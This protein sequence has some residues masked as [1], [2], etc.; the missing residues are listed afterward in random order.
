MVTCV[1]QDVYDA[2]LDAAGGVV[3]CWWEC[4]VK[5]HKCV[6]GQILTV[7]ET[8]SG[9]VGSLGATI[10]KEAGELLAN[11]GKYGVARSFQLANQEQLKSLLRPLLERQ[12]GHL[13]GRAIGRSALVAGA[14]G[15]FVITALVEAG[16][17]I[18]CGYSCSK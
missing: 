15:A 10:P 4:E 12:F 14:K 16:I 8:V 1:P 18:S 3:N 9:A 7:T 13:R 5:T 11:Q 17:S 2:A 6:G